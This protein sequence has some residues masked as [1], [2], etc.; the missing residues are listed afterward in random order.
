MGTTAQKLTYLNDTKGLLKDSINNLGGSITSSTTF[1]QYATELDTIYSKLP[2]ISGKGTAI[3]LTPTLKSRINSEL[4]GDTSQNGTPTPSS[5]V[6][7]QSVTGLQNVGV[8]GK[9]LING[10]LD[11]STT[12]K[13]LE[14]TIN[15]DENFYLYIKTNNTTSDRCYA[16]LDSTNVGTIWVSNNNGT[17]TFS[18]SRNFTFNRIRIQDN[19][20]VSENMLTLGSTATTY[21]AYN[22]NTYEVNLGKNLLNPSV[23]QQGGLDLGESGIETVSSARIRTNYIQV[24]PN[25]T[26]TISNN[27]TNLDNFGLG[28][29]KVDK[30]YDTEHKVN[31]GAWANFPYTFT[32]PSDTQY[33]RVTFRKSDNSYITP[34]GEYELQLEKGTQATSYSPYFTPIEL[35]KIGDYE[36]R[37]YKDSGKWYL[38][39]NIGNVT[40]NGTEGWSKNN[41]VTAGYLITNNS[42]SPFY[43]DVGNYGGYS[44]YFVSQD[45]YVTWTGAGKCGFNS[46]NVFWC[47]HTDTSLNTLEAF[48]D[49]VKAHPFKV[50]YVKT[51][52]T[53]TEITN[54]ELIEDLENLASAIGYDNQT[55]ISSN[56][57]LPVVISASMIKGAV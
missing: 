55:N 46:S 26:Y 10:L 25:T 40:L 3:N 20:T 47:M 45:S 23:L 41:Q 11:N 19:T 30:S 32:T 16:F 15:A 21:E 39:K 53:T 14:R 57:S 18:G 35:N 27:N 7:I 42:S 9:N 48:V 4:Y 43:N 17:L 51:T 28:Y 54:T 33:I 6:P 37:I 49:W 38:E 31:R 8:C 22:G 13:K 44:N 34:I 2:K 24:Q 1:R 36:D 5:P 29:Y 12:G 50:L 52:P 56:G